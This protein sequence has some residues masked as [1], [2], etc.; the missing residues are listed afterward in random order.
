MALL[1]D[2]KSSQAELEAQLSRRMAVFEEQLKATSPPTESLSK[3]AGDFYSFRDLVWGLLKSMRRQIEDC[4]NTIDA[5]EMRHRRKALLFSG[6][7][8]SV[9]NVS[10]AVVDVIQSKLEIGDI[11]ASQIVL[12]HRLGDKP[13][14]RCRPVLVRF[15]TYSL[16][17]TIWKKKSLLKGSSISISEFLTKMRQATFIKARSHFGMRE[18]WTSDGVITVKLGDG[19]RRKVN[20]HE[21]LQELIQRFPKPTASNVSKSD[22]R[23]PVALKPTPQATTSTATMKMTRKQTAKK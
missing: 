10:E 23:A 20:T 9:D 13:D 6:I 5:L 17:S 8:E 19:T 2:L 21:E 18:C 11:D 14:K 16:K 15:S 22:P 12:C 4:G 1:A 7:P 3:L